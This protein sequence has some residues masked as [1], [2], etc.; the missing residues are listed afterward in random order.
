MK[1]NKTTKTT[2]TNSIALKKSPK[3]LEKKIILQTFLKKQTNK[4]KQ[5]QINLKHFFKIP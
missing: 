3:T 1:K 2:T 5:N 4:T